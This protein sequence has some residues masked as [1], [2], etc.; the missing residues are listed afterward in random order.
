MAARLGNYLRVRR[1]EWQLSQRELAF[2]LGHRTE[3]IVSR[4]E[5]QERRI[6]LAMAFACYLIFG[7]KP[8]DLFPALFEEVEDGVVRRMFELYQRL[9]QSKPSKKN[10]TKLRL[11][12]E[13][14]A[15][16]AKR[17]HMP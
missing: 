5:R 1:R 16:A 13:A 6:T 3:S 4:Y 7:A 12:R 17:P 2:L 9:Q 11:L 10:D 15:R 14:L 8:K